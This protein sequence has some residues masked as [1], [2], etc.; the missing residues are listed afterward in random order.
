M[1][2]GAGHRRDSRCPEGPSV[3]ATQAFANRRT[4]TIRAAES[5]RPWAHHDRVHMV[6]RRRPYERRLPYAVPH[7]P[8]RGLLGLVP[9]LL[10]EGHDV[11]GLDGNGN[12][13][14][15]SAAMVAPMGERT[16]LATRLLLSGG[17]DP[18]LPPPSTARGPLHVAVCGIGTGPGAMAD[19][20]GPGP[21]RARR[22]R[23]E[24]GGH[25]PGEATRDGRPTG[26]PQ[27]LECPFSRCS[28]LRGG[29]GAL[30]QS[31]RQV[32]FP[33]RSPPALGPSRG[34]P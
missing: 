5:H 20:T 27:R 12:T 3:G 33:A 7:T 23:L 32:P 19:G 15:I 26:A 13:P 2:V 29:R 6:Y 8:P 10:D 11:N 31:R 30:Y 21:P 22:G 16:E 25:R 9:W 1:S 18:N 14:L 4:A 28:A 17:A 34:P 24:H